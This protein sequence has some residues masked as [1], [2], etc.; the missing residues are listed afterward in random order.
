[1]K[2][3]RLISTYYRIVSNEELDQKYRIIPTIPTVDVPSK[4]S[5]SRTFAEYF[6]EQVFL[7]PVLLY[8]LRI[9]YV[10]VLSTGEKSYIFQDTAKLYK[11]LVTTN[12][13][14]DSDELKK[15]FLGRRMLNLKEI[16]KIA[17]GAY[18]R[19]YLEPYMISEEDIY[20]KISRPYDIYIIPCLHEEKSMIEFSVETAY[21]TD[22]LVSDLE[23]KGFL[24]YQSNFEP[25]REV[26]DEWA[27]GFNW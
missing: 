3:R 2:G 21:I 27:E 16:A 4:E 14:S 1:M 6:D 9:A 13:I 12:C 26:I 7:G 11:Y 23:G 10:Y 24:E 20:I 22:T 5:K 25:P 15:Q 18:S 8:P 17:G 19:I